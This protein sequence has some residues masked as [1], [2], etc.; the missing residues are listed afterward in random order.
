MEKTIKETT[1]KLKNGI[2]TT[3]EADKILLD[4]FDVSKQRE[5]LIAFADAIN[6]CDGNIK[7]ISGL[8]DLYLKSN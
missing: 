4:L 8:V 6:I 5:Q 2:I 7:K 3:D 1:E